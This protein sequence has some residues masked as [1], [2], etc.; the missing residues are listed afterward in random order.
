MTT[1]VDKLNKKENK[2]NNYVNSSELAE[3]FN[4]TERRVQQLTGFEDDSVLEP[5]SDSK[6]Y[7]YNLMKAVKSFIK[8][9]QDQIN[10]KSHRIKNSE[11]EGQKLDVDIQLKELKLKTAQLEYDELDGKLHRSEDVEYM[12][13]DLALTIRGMLTA[14]PSRCADDIAG[15][16]DI[17]EVTHILRIEVNQILEKLS[18]Y[19]YDPK[20]Y[21]ELVTERNKYELDYDEETD[22]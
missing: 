20:K 21:K 12:T 1:P 11:K 18:R 10:G 17:K 2:I 4:L 16:D 6:P 22:D 13:S 9:Q 7:V 19:K 3:V 8:Y 5:V 14:I 15:L